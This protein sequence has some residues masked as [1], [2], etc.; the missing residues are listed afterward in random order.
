MTSTCSNT[1]PAVKQNNLG[2]FSV[3]SFL[4]LC[5]Q[6]H[7]ELPMMKDLGQERIVLTFL[8]YK[9]F[10]NLHPVIH[11]WA[12]MYAQ[13]VQKFSDTVFQDSKRKL[14]SFEILMKLGTSFLPQNL[15]LDVM[16]SCLSYFS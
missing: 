11:V 4:N 10:Q 3:L 12:N 9:T 1:L 2:V 15:E 5:N 16:T 7:L 8:P 6:S 13:K 14:N